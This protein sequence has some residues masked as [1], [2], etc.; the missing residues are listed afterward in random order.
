MGRW[1]GERAAVMCRQGCGRVGGSC[2]WWG[3]GGCCAVCEMRV[4]EGQQER[5]TVAG[6]PFAAK[7]VGGLMAVIDGSRRAQATQCV[8]V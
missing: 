1:E 7:C 8:F 6:R 5:G 4:D 3:E 2:G